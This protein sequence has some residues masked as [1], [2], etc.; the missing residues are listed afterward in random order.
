MRLLYTAD[1]RSQVERVMR[2][3]RLKGIDNRIVTQEW[4]CGFATPTTKPYC[5]HIEAEADWKRAASALV[6]IGLAPIVMQ[7]KVRILLALIS[8]II[9][10]VLI[11]VLPGI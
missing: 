5:V 4:S 7:S 3:L 11:A 1:D 2:I 8:L 9:G 6:K 10:A